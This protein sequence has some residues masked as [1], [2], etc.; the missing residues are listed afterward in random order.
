VKF[1]VDACYYTLSPQHKVCR[2]YQVDNDG[3][4]RFFCNVGCLPP[5]VHHCFSENCS[6]QAQ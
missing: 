1:D 5:R 3:D 6:F 4:N 2:F